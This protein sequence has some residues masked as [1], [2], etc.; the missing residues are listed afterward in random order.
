MAAEDFP[1]YLYHYTDSRGFLGI[2]ESRRLWASSIRHLNDSAE[3]HHVADI[4]QDAVRS[5]NEHLPTREQLLLRYL[6]AQLL[7]QPAEF[8]ADYIRE[9]NVAGAMYVACFSGHRDDL[10]QWRAY[11]KQ[12]GVCIAVDT[13]KLQSIAA[14]PTCGSRGVFMNV[15]Q[16]LVW[17]RRSWTAF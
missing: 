3:C 12:G 1:Q 13:A 5:K 2:V 10:S 14:H 4:V 17:Q 9:M 8:S 7:S 6:N 16:R 11:G 15:L